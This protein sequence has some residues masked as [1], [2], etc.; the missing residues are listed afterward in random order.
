MAQPGPVI[1]AMWLIGVQIAAPVVLATK[2]LSK[3]YVERRW[4]GKS[5]EV[6]AASE[7]T[8]EVRKG[9]TL[10][11]V[12]ESGSGKSTVGRTLLRLNAPTSGSIR[13]AGRPSEGVQR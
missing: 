10:G 2:G 5:R 6:R 3:I 1:T 13:L 11:L 4:I 7:V 8:L 9:Q 12:G